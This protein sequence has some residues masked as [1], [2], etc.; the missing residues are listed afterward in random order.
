MGTGI[1]VKRI[2]CCAQKDFYIFGYFISLH[3]AIC[4]FLRMDFKQEAS[5]ENV[6]V[7][8][9]CLKLNSMLVRTGR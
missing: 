4:E 6:K 5:A 9:T 3:N 7:C 8:R 1:E 2:R